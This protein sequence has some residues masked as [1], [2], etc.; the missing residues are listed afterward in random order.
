MSQV[1]L[2]D[3]SQDMLRQHHEQRHVGV[4]TKDNIDS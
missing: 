2:N 1:E 4:T 3:R